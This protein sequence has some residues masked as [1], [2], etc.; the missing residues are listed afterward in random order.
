MVEQLSSETPCQLYEDL[1]SARFSLDQKRLRDSIQKILGYY[2]RCYGTENMEYIQIKKILCLFPEDLRFATGKL[3]WLRNQL[4]YEC[5][6]S[7]PSYISDEKKK[8]QFRNV[9][10]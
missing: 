1:L 6:R 2:E 8:T 10:D 3:E 7:D 5:R 9:K 4:H